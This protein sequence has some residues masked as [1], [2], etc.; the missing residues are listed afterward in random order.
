MYEDT[1]QLLCESDTFAALQLI[2][3]DGKA[4]EIAQRYDELVRDLYWKAK[5]V[6]A[7]IVVARGGIHYC[8]TTMAEMNNYKDRELFGG[9]AKKMAFNLASF[10]WPGWDEP[11]VSLSSGDIAVGLDA[12]KLNLRLAAELERPPER[13]EEAHWLLG[14]HFLAVGEPISA[15][16]EFEQASPGTRPLF[17]GYRLL[18]QIILGREGAPRMFDDLLVSMRGQDD[19]DQQSNATQLA[20]AH[21]VFVSP[22]NSA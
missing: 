17:D 7:V 14:A 4:V 1:I 21:R 15:L 12:A 9:F 2:E 11:G 19:Q 8:L 5:N 22:P 16:N 3:R 18:A 13:I 20:T 10:L 6:A